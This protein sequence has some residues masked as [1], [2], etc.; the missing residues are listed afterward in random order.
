MAFFGSGTFYNSGSFYVGAGSNP[1]EGIP[2]DLRFYRSS[3][4]GIYIFW[5]GFDPEFISPSLAFSAFDLQLD[6]SPLF[7][8]PNLVTFTSSID[9][10]A[11]IV[12][13]VTSVTDSTHLVVS[14]TSGMSGGDNIR[15]GSN[16][17]TITTVTDSTHLVV[18]STSGWVAS[19]IITFQNGNVRKGFAVPVAARQ[20]GIV[21]TWYARVRTHTPAFVSAY[22]TTLTWTIPQKVQQQYAEALM[23]SLPDYHVYGKGDLLKPLNQR[24]TNLWLVEDM[25]GNQFDQVYYANFLTQTDNY[26]TL[27]VDENLYQNFGVLFSYP[28][29]NSMQYVDYRWILMNL[30][31]AS[32][33]GSTNEAIILTVQAFTGVPPAITPIRD[34]NDFFLVTIQ[35]NP[36]VPSGPQAVFHTSQP[37]IDA[38]LVVEDITT[39]LLVPSSAYTTDGAQGTWTMNVPTTDTLQAV[40]NVGNPGDPFPVV[41][42]ALQGAFTLTGFVTFTN[43]SVNIGGFGTLFTTQ[44][45]V[46]DE[47]T[48]PY[49][50][51]LGTI[52]HITDDT[53]AQLVNTWAGPTEV[54]SAYRL[55]YTDT[56]LPPPILWDQSTLKAGVL[57]TI[58]NPGD[59]LL[60]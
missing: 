22:S 30:I 55:L 17:A 35:D 20:E 50:I 40:F 11:S 15:Q 28:K 34:E 26:I 27:C 47:I 51:Y 31:Q 57:I 7:T 37:Y 2:E 59:F 24:N 33:V 9:T 60:N 53:H 23:N 43:G 41:F 58:F 38:S 39:G 18:S 54:N 56:Q 49:G 3:I 52:A 21:Q 46:G 29:P 44:L 42:D 6:T 8:S 45:V 14:S 32:L 13:T 12:F 1:T 16:S 5:W 19:G 4:D 36:I 48:D 10:T 25:Y